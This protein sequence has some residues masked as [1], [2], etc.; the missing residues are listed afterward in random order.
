MRLFLVNPPSLSKNLAP[1]PPAGLA[2]IAAFVR[3]N[4]YDVDLLDATNLRLDHRQTVAHVRS[5]QP[6]LVGIS[7]VSGTHNSTVML[8]KLLHEALPQAKIVLG[9]PHVH[10]LYEEMM[11][12]HAWIDFCVRGEGEHTTLELLSA[13]E[14]GTDLSGIPGLIHR[15]NGRL[16]VNQDRPFIKELDSLPFP[17]RD[18]LPMNDYRW[19]IFGFTRPD[20]KVVTITATRGC[21]F[22]CHFCASSYLW[23]T[24]RRRSVENVLDEIGKCAEEYDIGMLLFPDDMLLLNEKWAITLC[25]GMIERGYDRFKWACMGRPGR[26]SADMLDWLKK[27]RCGLIMYGIEFGNQR[28]LDFCNRRTTLSDIESTIAATRAR[29]ILTMGFFIFGYP[30][31]TVETIEQTIRFA[32]KLKLDY[33]EFNLSKALPGSPLYDYCVERDLLIDTSDQNY[34][35]ISKQMIMLDDITPAELARLYRKALRKTRYSSAWRLKKFSRRMLLRRARR[36]LS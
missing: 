1:L 16:L 3:S 5:S 9:G 29:G 30:T 32:R 25:R 6:D 33:A 14:Q 4:G 23:K 21:P 36:K 12:E 8:G 27:A 26:M 35:S 19:R 34:N 22:H 2:Y 17:A 18:L 15:M 11:Q 7:V 13:L 10:F 28:L 20:D 24:Q 31:E